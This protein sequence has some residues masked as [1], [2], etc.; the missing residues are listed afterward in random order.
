MNFFKIHKRLLI[1][2]DI[3]AQKDDIQDHYKEADKKPKT[4]TAI[5]KSIILNKIE[6]ALE[7]VNIE[8]DHLNEEKHFSNK[9]DSVL[10]D[11]ISWNIGREQILS[12]FREY[13][14]AMPDSLYQIQRKGS[15]ILEI[16]GLDGSSFELYHLKEIIGGSIYQLKDNHSNQTVDIIEYNYLEKLEKTSENGYLFPD[17]NMIKALD[18]LR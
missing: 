15:Q 3:K 7:Q 16:N 14:E 12:E 6:S 17:D 8:R 11:R 9:H 4:E 1:S 13:V 5:V 18:Q 10:M 2:N